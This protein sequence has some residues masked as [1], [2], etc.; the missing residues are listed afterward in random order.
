M[1]QPQG[2]PRS[3]RR[4]ALIAMMAAVAALASAPSAAARAQTSGSADSLAQ[5]VPKGWFVA[6]ITKYSASVDSVPGTSGR[7]SGRFASLP[8]PAPSRDVSGVFAQAIRPDS[9]VRRHLRVSANIRSDLAAFRTSRGSPSGAGLYVRVDLAD[10]GFLVGN[11]G[12]RQIT[13]RTDWSRYAVEVDVPANAIGIMFGVAVQG[14]GQVWMDDVRVD[15]T[16][17]MSPEPRIFHAQVPPTRDQITTFA[18]RFTKRPPLPL[19]LDF[20]SL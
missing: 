15:T 18:A 13:G 20:E 5:L 19:N 9:L 3:R 14:V 6:P 1:Q 8:D 11:T 4:G 10:G 12:D 17:P 16:G 2:R 7:A